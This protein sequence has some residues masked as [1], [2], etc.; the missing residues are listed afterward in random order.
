MRIH[1][2]ATAWPPCPLLVPRVRIADALA[3]LEI[4]AEAVA[5]DAE[6][7]EVTT[8]EVVVVRSSPASL[9]L[10]VGVT[11]HAAVVGPSGL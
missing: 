7:A 3:R 10:A 1:V 6:G 2:G 4:P 9:S 8:L 5:V 11:G